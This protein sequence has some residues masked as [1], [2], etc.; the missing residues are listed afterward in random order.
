MNLALAHVGLALPQPPD[1][2]WQTFIDIVDVESGDLR[3]G[4]PATAPSLSSVGT[5]W[6]VPSAKGA[7]M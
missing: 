4:S 5:I 3:A 7:M 1:K 2:V 6:G